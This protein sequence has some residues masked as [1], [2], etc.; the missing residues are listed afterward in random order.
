[1]RVILTAAT[2]LAAYWAALVVG[3]DSPLVTHWAYLVLHVAFVAPVIARAILKREHRLAW[4][5]LATGLTLW[6]LGS[7]WQVAGD[8]LGVQR[9]PFPSYSD[10]LWLAAYPFVF[11][12]LGC[13]ARPWLRRAPVATL[14]ETLAVGLGATALVAAAVARYVDTNAGELTLLGRIVTLYYPVAD[15]GLLAVAVIGA[16]IAGWKAGRTWMLIALGALALV[17]GDGLW[18][19]QASAGTWEPVMSSNA[20]F[21]LWPA[22]AALAAW[23]P[24]QPDRTSYL[25]SGVRTHL[26]A[27]ASAATSTALLVANEWFAIPAPAVVLAALSLLVTVH[28]T[29]RALAVSLREARETA[30]ERDLVEDVRDAMRNGELDLHFQPLVDLEGRV[31][32]AEALLRWRRADGVF[33]PPDAFLPVVERSE[34]MRTLTDWVLDRALA[35]A[36]GWHRSGHCIGVSVNLA[37]RNLSEAD[38]PGRVLTALRRNEFP[39]HKLT[40]EITETAAVEDKP[41]TAH[42][43]GALRRLGVELAVDDFGTGHSSLVRLAEFP[44]SELKI[45]RSFVQRMHESERP[46]VATAIRLARMLGLRVVAEGVE[47]QL[48]LDALTEL[49]C[50]LAQGYYISRPLPA[51]EFAGWLNHPALV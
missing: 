50:D 9:P 11:V 35:A 27:L 20:V 36:S 34:L 19:L 13:F 41:L 28:G 45:D 29:G 46:I 25:A 26:A 7:I 14:F 48:T 44:I 47:D 18:A 31:H 4:A 5:S 16:T 3:V 2:V 23:L 12:T 40:L 51:V 38:L 24:N 10:V 33:V 39:A 6:T 43:L 32:G 37:T 42:V 30:R 1:M 22:F 17:V 8:A 15:S 21:P 49:D